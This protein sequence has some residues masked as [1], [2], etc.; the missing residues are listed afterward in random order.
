MV[1]NVNVIQRVPNLPIGPITDKDGNPT[2]NEQIFRQALI[3]LLQL[4]LSP[5]GIVAPV[6][7]PANVTIIQNAIDGI[8]NQATC[9]PGTL[10]YSQHPTDYTQDALVVAFRTSNTPGVVPSFKTVTV[11]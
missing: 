9:L 4:Y 11:T 7:A 2:Q 5:E 6:Q 3:D 1:D 10:L 8:T